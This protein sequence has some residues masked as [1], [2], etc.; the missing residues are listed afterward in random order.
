MQELFRPMLEK[1]KENVTGNIVKLINT[2]HKKHHPVF[3]TQHRDSGSNAKIVKFCNR[4]P[5][6]RGSENWELV[7]EIKKCLINKDTIIEKATYDAFHDT[8]LN[9]RLSV[10]GVDTVVVIKP[11]E[12]IYTKDAY[13]FL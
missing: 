7:P 13:D 6:Y 11:H 5:L 8:N 2:C 4:D 1:A 12:G 3:I 10:L 9:E